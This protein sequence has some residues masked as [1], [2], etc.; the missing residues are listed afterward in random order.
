LKPS[1]AKPP[2]KAPIRRTKK[3]HVVKCHPEPF[4]ALWRGRKVHEIR[5][6]DRDYRV[7][8]EL[9]QREWL[10]EE[11]V[12]TNREVR[13]LVTYVT[14][15]PSWAIPEGYCVMSLAVFATVVR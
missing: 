3:T 7:G 13:A 14:Y 1:T 8:D 12:F 10:P 2:A 9:R 4:E 6:N 5:K 11:G 15:G